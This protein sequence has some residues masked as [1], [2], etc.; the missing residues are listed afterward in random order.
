MG[1]TLRSVKIELCLRLFT[2]A[3]MPPSLQTYK[4][5]CK[6]AQ[7]GGRAADGFWA[8]SRKRFGGPSTCD[9]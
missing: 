7:G 9:D 5:S 1:N 8:V 4:L 6:E 3:R 2:P